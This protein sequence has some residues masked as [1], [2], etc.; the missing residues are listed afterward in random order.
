MH[1]IVHPI[2][3]ELIEILCSLF[4]PNV[5]GHKAGKGYKTLSKE[6]GLPAYGT[7]V[8]LPWPGQPFKVSS[9]A[10]ARLVQ[11]DKADPRATR[12]ELRED[13]MA[14]GTLFSINT[15]SN[16][17]YRNGLRSRRAR[18]VPLLSKHHVKEHLK[19]AHDRL[20]HSETKIKVFGADH[21]RGVWQE[22][23][24]A[25][26]PKNTIPTVKHGGGNIMLWGYF[27]AKGPGHLVCI[28]G[29]MDSTAYVEILAKNLRSVIMDLK[30]GRHFIL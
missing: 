30:M 6:F 11:T 24:T 17:L 15:I 10:E 27:S 12:R 25:Y 3:T 20:E 8:N 19:F 26:D 13:L 14:V 9:R 4:I 21:T 23:G 29:K 16:V 5:E 7:T 2:R 22:D 18:K 28:H 1:N